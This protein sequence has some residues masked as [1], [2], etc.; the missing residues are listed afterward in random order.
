MAPPQWEGG[1]LFEPPTGFFTET[2]VTPERKVKKSFPRSEIN[3]HAKGK[4]WVIEQN[5]GRLAKIGFFG[6]NRDFGPKKNVT[7]L[8]PNHIL[9][10][11]GKSC[12]KKKVAFSQINISLLRNFN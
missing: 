10:T 12:S 4:K 8:E 11:T 1:R 6:Q 5:W 9:A 3:R 7:L 2:A